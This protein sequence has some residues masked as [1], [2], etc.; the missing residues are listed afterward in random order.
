MAA[1]GDEVATPQVVLISHSVL[2]GL[3]PFIPVPVLDGFVKLTIER[4]LV[5]AIAKHRS[6]SLHPDAVREL[7]GERTSAFGGIVRSIVKYPFRTMLRKLFIAL[8]VK[9]ASDE[10]SLAYHRAYLVDRALARGLVA[11][12]GEHHSSAV[13]DAI[14]K[15]CEV[16]PVS[17]LTHAL[18]GAFEASRL[19]LGLLGRRLLGLVTKR[20]GSI[21]DV[22]LGATV[23]AAARSDVFA[24]ARVAVEAVP[25]EH[26]AALERAFDDALMRR[27]R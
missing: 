22:E 20:E 8:Q 18:S 1:D 3:T 19:G 5:V 6:F 23:E 10:A 25:R 27:N 24:R 14:E 21:D 26:F 9:R 11:P 15:A 17:P 12:P 4:R 13:R 2:V 16:V 7:A